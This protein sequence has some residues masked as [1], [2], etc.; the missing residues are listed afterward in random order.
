MLGY[1]RNDLV[2]NKGEFSVRGDIVDIALSEKEGVRIELWGDEVD[3]I[4]M[5]S[6]SSQR[7]N[8]MIE[9]IEIM[10]AHEF[11]LEDDLSVIIKNLKKKKKK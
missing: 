5:F 7:S 9:K 1:E 10:P 11:V 6:L 3:S 4:R 2:E 8:E